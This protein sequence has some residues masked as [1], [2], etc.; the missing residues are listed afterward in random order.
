MLAVTFALPLIEFPKRA[1]APIPFGTAPVQFAAELQVPSPVR[2]QVP[3]CA[4]RPNGSKDRPQA[5]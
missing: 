5:N 4:P 2:F 3:V 1:V